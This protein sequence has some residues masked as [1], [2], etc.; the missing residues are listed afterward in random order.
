MA[1]KK[2]FSIFFFSKETAVKLEWQRGSIAAG[3]R[4]G[5]S[6]KQRLLNLS[7]LRQ[8]TSE[9]LFP[10][11]LF[12]IV[13][14]KEILGKLALTVIYLWKN[15]KWKL[16]PPQSKTFDP[17]HHWNHLRALKLN[18][19]AFIGGHESLHLENERWHL[20]PD[21]SDLEILGHILLLLSHLHPP[22]EI[23]QLAILRADRDTSLPDSIRDFQT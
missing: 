9:F 20:A 21:F 8:E 7:L 16:F 4:V 12:S 10:F 18:R 22:L 14:H 17:V 19:S 6:G 3:A 2:H 1:I 13:S 5:I 15:L 11:Q 23:F